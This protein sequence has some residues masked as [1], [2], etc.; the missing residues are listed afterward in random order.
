MGRDKV[1]ETKQGPSAYTCGITGAVIYGGFGGSNSPQGGL[2]GSLVERWTLKQ[3]TW[4]IHYA[5]KLS[6]HCFGFVLTRLQSKEKHLRWQV[7][8]GATDLSRVKR[9]FI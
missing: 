6:D 7:D 8:K 1:G 2:R 9:L 5:Y 4:L 3:D